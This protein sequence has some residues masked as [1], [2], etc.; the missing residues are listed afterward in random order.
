MIS[1]TSLGDARIPRLRIGMKNSSRRRIWSGDRLGLQIRWTGAKASG[2]SGSIP[3]RLRQYDNRAYR[4]HGRNLLLVLYALFD[5]DHTQAFA[6]DAIRNDSS[7]GVVQGGF[8]F[9]FAPAP[10]IESHASAAAGPAH[11]GRF[12]AG[13]P[14]YL[15]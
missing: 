12:G 3:T 4:T 6:S 11:L 10:A 1:Q 8:D 14:R 15:N 2:R 13:P 9:G 5:F 7:S